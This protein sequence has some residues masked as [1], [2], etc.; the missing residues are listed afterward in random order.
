MEYILKNRVY[1]GEIPYKG[2]SFKGK[3]QAII[4]QREWNAAHTALRKDGKPLRSNAQLMAYRGVLICGE[5]AK[6]LVG[7]KKKSGKH[8]YY[9]CLKMKNGCTQGYINEKAIDSAISD[10]FA[11]LQFSDSHKEDIR[12]MVREMQSLK[13]G[14]EAN[15]EHQLVSRLQSAKRNLSKAYSDRLEGIIDVDD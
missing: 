14:E 2:E 7:E 6:G 9:R 8:T 13:D 4:T 5:C 15:Q 12:R 3:H 1:I 10:T 11:K